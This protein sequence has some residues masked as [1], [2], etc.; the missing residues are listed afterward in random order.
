[1]SAHNITWNGSGGQV[2]V[3]GLGAVVATLGSWTLK[4]RGVNHGDKPLWDLHGFLSYV[5]PTLYKALADKGYDLRIT[6][7]T[8]NKTYEVDHFERE[9]IEI[10]ETNIVAK[11]ITFN[12]RD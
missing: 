2:K 6:L 9:L 10:T 12:V 11:E 7:T 5:N 3:A 8:N 4:S 1:M